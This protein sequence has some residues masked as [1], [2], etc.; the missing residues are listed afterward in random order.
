MKFFFLDLLGEGAFSKVYRGYYQAAEVAVKMLK[1]PLNAQ[2]KNYFAAEVSL[3][4]D[5][6]HPRVVLLLGVCTDTKLPLMVL[7]YMSSGNLFNILHD[8]RRSPLDH[9]EFYQISSDIAAGMVYL[10]NNRPPVLHLDLKSMNVLI[11]AGNRAKIADFGF[12]KHEA[13]LKAAKNKQIQGSPGWMAPELLLNGEVTVKADVYSFGIILWE[14]V[15]RKHPYEGCSMFQVCA[16]VRLNQRPEFPDHCP[17]ELRK[18]I[19]KCWHHNPAKRLI[20][21][22]SSIFVSNKVTYLF[23]NAN[24]HQV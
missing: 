7:E 16:Q 1:V 20:F 15:T 11:G 5:L 8:T 6:R 14:M 3:L 19:Q 17:S 12:S 22:V 18:L 4:R 9:V 13:D 2:D 23:G 21:K 24:G 10:H